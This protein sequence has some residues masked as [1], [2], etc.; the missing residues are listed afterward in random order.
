MA[1]LRE[2]ARR[3]LSDKHSVGRFSSGLAE[4]VPFPY[5]CWK[6]THYSDF[7][8]FYVTIPRGYKN[9]YVNSFFRHIA[10]SWSSLPVEWVPLTYD[11]KEFQSAFN[12]QFLS[13]GS[14]WS[15]L[16]FAFHLYLILFLTTPCFGVAAYPSVK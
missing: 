7:M 1:H 8:I 14:S 10:R 13:L 3:S 9:I 16:L 11:L 12:R 6:F 5:S 15:A 4:L 2:V